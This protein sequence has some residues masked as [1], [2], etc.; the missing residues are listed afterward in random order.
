MITSFGADLTICPNIV[1]TSDQKF[2]VNQARNFSRAINGYFINQYDNHLNT[3]C[4][5]EKTGHEIVDY[6]YNTNQSLDYFITVGGSGGTVTGCAKKIKEYFPNVKV[7]MP[8]PYGSVYYDLFYHQRVID[9]NIKKYK[10]EG[11]GN[12]IN[13]S[14]MNLSYIDKVIQFSDHEAFDACDKLSARHGL[15]CGH[16]SG[17]NYF[18]YLKL[19]SSIKKN[20]AANILIMLPDSGMK[21]LC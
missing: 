1:N 6:F 18:G 17:A 15:L 19:L 10:V 13:C 12:P 21:Y 9:S 20:R 11:P 7:I 3:K 2:Y 8:D 5:Y 14:S 16:S 4:H